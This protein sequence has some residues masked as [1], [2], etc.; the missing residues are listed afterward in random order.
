[1]LDRQWLTIGFALEGA[2]LLALF[3]RVPHAGL[4]RAG[5]AVLAGAFARLILNPDV[6]TWG[7][8]DGLPV[9]NGLLY[10]FAVVIAAL[11]AGARLSDDAALPHGRRLLLALGTTALFA[12][13]NL[14]I[15]HFFT[16]PG[17]ATLDLS[18]TGNLARDMSYTLAWSAF[19]LGLVI[20]GLRRDLRPAR[21]AGAVLFGAALLKL[22]LHDLARL[23]N[24]YRIG[25]LFGVAVVALAASTLYQ[26]FFR[27]R[28]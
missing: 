23:D 24:L 10:P 13:V 7:L 19:A 25:A 12:L 21:L 27:Q 18:F 16:P 3:R 26:R 1:Q 17:R 5:T 6:V 15:A 28:A 11:Y 22:F 4:V 8:P 2:A 20:V 14:Q 9:F